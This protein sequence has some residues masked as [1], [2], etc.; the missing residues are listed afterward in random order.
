MGRELKEGEREARRELKEGSKERI[1]GGGRE[2]ERGKRAG[3]KIV[4]S[5]CTYIIHVNV[6]IHLAEMGC[7]AIKPLGSLSATEPM[8]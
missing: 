4:G 3:N 1:K 7:M 5:L 6:Y 8:M 2:R